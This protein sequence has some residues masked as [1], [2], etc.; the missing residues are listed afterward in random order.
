MIN[1][2]V[3]FKNRIYLKTKKKVLAKS[4]PCH[5]TA[6]MNYFNHMI[7]NSRFSNTCVTFG[8]NNSILYILM[9]LCGFTLKNRT[10]QSNWIAFVKRF[11]KINERK[12]ASC[13]VSCVRIYLNSFTQRIFFLI[14]TSVFFKSCISFVVWQ[15]KSYDMF[16]DGNN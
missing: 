1:R 15:K 11:Y 10:R 5:F 12:N 6:N 13:K 7:T 14:S 3:L 4:W 16:F 2:N 9:T 8:N